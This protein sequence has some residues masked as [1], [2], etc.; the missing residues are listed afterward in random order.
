MSP[1]SILLRL[2][3]IAFVMLT[4][5]LTGVPVAPAPARAT[6]ISIDRQVAASEDDCFTYGTTFNMTGAA[7]YQDLSSVLC[8]T[9]SRFD[10]ITIPQGA[11]ITFAAVDVASY[12]NYTGTS[13]LSID[14]EDSDNAATFS[15]LAD[16]TGRALTG[17]A[18][19]WY[20]GNWTI[21]TWYGYTNDS[22]NLTVPVQHVINRGTWTSGNALVVKIT[23][24][25]KIMSRLLRTWDYVSTP[26]NAFGAKLHIEYTST[27]TVVPP[28]VTTQNATSVAS[29]TATGNGNITDIG[30]ESCD[31]R[32]ICYSSTNATPTVAD[33][34]QESAGS[35][36][37]GAFTQSLTGLSAATTYYLRAYAHNSAGYG[38]GD[39]V[40]ILTLPATPGSVA[41]SDG[42]H[43]DGVVI[44]WTAATGTITGYYVYKTDVLIATLNSTTLLWNDTAADSPT[45]TVGTGTASDGASS[46]AVALNASSQATVNGTTYT[47]KVSAY[48]ATG[49]GAKVS[50]TGYRGIGI[51]SGVAPLQVNSRWGAML[52]GKLFVGIYGSGLPAPL[53]R[54]VRVDAAT[55]ATEAEWVAGAGQTNLLPVCT[56]GTAIFAGLHVAGL[57]ADFVRIDPTTMQAT[58]TFYGSA[59]QSYGRA[60]YSDNTDVFA[61]YQYGTS[62]YQ[63]LRLTPADMAFE[64]GTLSTDIFLGAS[65]VGIDGDTNNIYVITINSL[66]SNH[67]RLYKILKSSMAVDSYFEASSDNGSSVAIIGDRAYMA[68]GPGLSYIQ[69]AE[70]IEVYTSNMTATGR[71]WMGGAG[72]TGAAKINTDGTY[73]YLSLFTTPGKVIKLDPTGTDITVAATWTGG[74]ST[75]DY[76]SSVVVSGARRYLLLNETPAKVLD[77]DSNLT[78]ISYQWWRSSGDSDA[79]YS[80]IA[81]ATTASYSDTGGVYS[82]DGRYYICT[83]SA[84][85]AASQNTTADRGYMNT[86]AS[87]ITLSPAS[88]IQTTTATLNGNIAS[89]GSPNPTV[90]VYW[91]ETNGGQTPGS[92]TN[93]SLPDTAQ[94]Q[95]VG[96]FSLNVTSLSIGTVYYFSASANASDNISWPAASLSFTTR[97]AAPTAVAATDGT[98]TANV[99]VS[100]NGSFGATYYHVI[101]G[102]T[103]LGSVGN[104]TEYADTGAPLGLIIGGSANATKGASASYIT[105]A[106][107][108]QSVDNGTAATYKVVAYTSG[109]ASADS[110]TDNG[111]R[112]VGSLSEVWQESA[113]DSDATYTDIAGTTTPFNWTGGPSDGTARYYRVRVSA[114]GAA[115][116]YSSADRGFMYPYPATPATDMTGVVA[117]MAIFNGYVSQFFGLFLVVVI[118]AFAFYSK[119]LWVMGLA[120]LPSLLY[121]LNLAQSA[122]VNSST[123]V[124]GIVLALIG[125]GCLFKVVTDGL[126]VV[127]GQKAK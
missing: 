71:T 85:G 36:G 10:N 44:S 119:S 73:L 14:F 60:L 125:L 77:L 4:S 114:A 11:T 94:P 95:G 26:S 37:T 59:N 7:N 84:T 83:V 55:M 123:W 100:W 127:R 30:Y 78:K 41:A 40:T 103:D 116:G 126:K 39:P 86:V 64:S 124:A 47:Y 109:G 5:V 121:G 112:S 106:Y 74:D 45:V 79:D 110:A 51:W 20:P 61:V 113:A 38:Y 50:N 43:T 97:P 58:H 32:G 67:A 105:L 53:G 46:M 118:L 28:T 31:L 65:V 33:S 115:D 98:Y 76:A 108:G 66:T 23:A 90:T 25:A 81:G 89:V 87:A 1:L 122:T 96:P 99:T 42:T 82:P 72:Q 93:S 62:A 2:V 101:R 13:N 107:S 104:V 29:T 56:D 102:T 17:D 9:Y 6:T 54:V 63:V 15:T 34:K 91:G 16:A 12:G 57:G 68:L 117:Q 22:Q 21:G 19:L 92:W 48:N 35:F 49:E 52:N 8:S 88:A 69:P 80:L 24:T 120:A 70:V 111:Y 3:V 18:V 27:E 75:E